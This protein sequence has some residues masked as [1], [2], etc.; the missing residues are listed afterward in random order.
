MSDYVITITFGDCAENHVGM[1]KLGEISKH[2]LSC[3]ELKEIKKSFDEKDYVTE[4]ID[5]FDKGNMVG[6]DFK[7]AGV[8]IIRNGYKV[9][10]EDDDNISI[11]KLNEE[12]LGCN[13]DKKA[14]MRGRVVNKKARYNLVFSDI[15][16]E[17]EYEYKKGRIIKYD[18]VPLL[19]KIRNTLHKYLNKKCEKLQGEG[20]YYY[21]MKNTYIGFHGD[22]ERKKVVAIRLGNTSMPLHFQWFLLSEPVGE[23]VVIDLNPGDIYIMSEKAVG[24]DWLKKSIPTL[25]HGTAKNEK[26]LNI[27]K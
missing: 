11:E 5:L 1:Q 3:Y 15:S 9:F 12:M 26:F 10:F 22:A 18:D 14:W 24:T 7:E 8:L 19:S 21:D 27:K 20:N 23:R 16:Q 13:W 4:Y 6:Y 25:R 17:P 2:G